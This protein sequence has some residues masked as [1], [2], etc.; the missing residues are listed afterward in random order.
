VR[1]AVH[2]V[3]HGVRRLKSE[4]PEL[5]AASGEKPSRKRFYVKIEKEI[6]FEASKL[7]SLRLILLVGQFVK[8]ALLIK[9]YLKRLIKPFYLR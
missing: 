7:E 1:R 4:G 8:Q 9:R 5:H 3:W 6:N 2:Q